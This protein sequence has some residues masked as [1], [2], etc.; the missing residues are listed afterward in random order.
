VLVTAS[1]YR[2]QLD[3]YGPEKS[4]QATWTVLDFGSRTSGAEELTLTLEPTLAIAGR[5]I[6]DLPK[7]SATVHVHPLSNPLPFGLLPTG[8]NA[9]VWAH[10]GGEF[11]IAGLAP[12][13]YDVEVRPNPPYPTAWVRDVEA[14]TEDLSVVLGGERPARVT[15]DVALSEGKSKETILLTGR[16]TPHDQPPAVA[17]LPWQATYP[18]PLGWPPGVSHLWS[19]GG[20]LTDELGWT[21]FGL[22][23]IPENPTTIE[24]DEGPYW[25]G[26]K[27][28]AEDGNTT[29]PMGTGLVHVTAGEHRLR[30]ELTPSGSVEGRVTGGPS[31]RELFAALA[32]GGKLL[33]LDVRRDEMR[34]VSELGADGFFR[35]PL[36]PVGTLELRIGTREELLAGRWTHHQELRVARGETL[37][38]EVEL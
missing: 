4:P 29:F 21:Q 5:I 22:G 37:A 2:R 11:R 7:L 31:G 8:V 10:K 33:T 18:D 36:V 6:S 3:F 28:R 34:S 23:P 32:H 13:R 19:G 20:G 30:F 24:L 16:L 12:G 15:I 17:E 14:G 1:D 26:I 38:V 9:S 25:I 35:F 27:A